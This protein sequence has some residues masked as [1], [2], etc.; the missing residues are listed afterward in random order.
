MA[1]NPPYTMEAMQCYIKYAR[2]IKPR[3]T[4]QVRGRVLCMR[5]CVCVCRFAH[6]PLTLLRHPPVSA[7][8]P[9]PASAAAFHC[10]QAQ[11]QLVLSYKKLRGDD[12]APGSATAYRITVRP[13]YLCCGSCPVL[14]SC[15][16]LFYAYAALLVAGRLL[17]CGRPTAAVRQAQ[18]GSSRPSVLPQPRE[19]ARPLSAQPFSFVD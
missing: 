2:A 16:L 7:H 3:I 6:A 18:A 11:R 19:T 15:V 12:A 8:H 5:R 14:A 4:Q 10:L 13:R 1:L 17:F 9:D